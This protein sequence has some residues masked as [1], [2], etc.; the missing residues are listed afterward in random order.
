MSYVMQP[1]FATKLLGT[2]M[3]KLTPALMAETVGCCTVVLHITLSRLP[4]AELNVS[5]ISLLAVTAV[6]STTAD[7]EPAA[8]VTAPA[9]A[10]QQA[11]G[12]AF[13]EQ[14]VVVPNREDVSLPLLEF[15]RF[16]VGNVGEKEPPLLTTTLGLEGP[17]APQIPTPA[18]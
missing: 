12:D 1:G 5:E 2:D 15:T 3:V 4:S 16:V 13:D 8:I 11:A 18:V 9:A 6:V 14:F 17:A 10:D 7:D